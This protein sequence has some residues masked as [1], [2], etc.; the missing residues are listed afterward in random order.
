MLSAKSFK[1][2]QKIKEDELINQWGKAKTD[3]FDFEKIAIYS[4][5]K[6]DIFFHRLSA[7]TKADIDFDD[8]FY[9]V[10]R[11]TSRVGQQFLY[12]V[13]S[14][15]TNDETALLKLN[16][17]A[18]FFRDNEAVRIEVQLHLLKLNSDDAYFLPNLLKDHSFVKPI[19]Y[20]FVFPS[21][22]LIPLLVLL[23]PL[24]HTLLLW[25]MVPLAVNVFLHYRNK[26]FTKRFYKLFQQLNIL[27]NICKK[28]NK[29]QLPFD[30]DLVES[31][32]IKLKSIQRKSRL[33][34]FDQ[35]TIKDEL[36]QAS[37]YLYELIKAIFLIEF[38]TFYS[39]LKDIDKKQAE[40][41]YL[42]NYIGQI[43][44][45]L[46][47][48]SLRAAN[49]ST[50]QPDF[51]SASK[52]F[53]CTKVYHP[54]IA[55]CVTND[56]TVATK[57]VLITGSNMSGKTTFLR[58]LALNS[59]LAQT[60]FTCFAES[61][62]TPFV[63]LH[64]SVRIDDNLLD[65]KS[66]YFEEVTV[67]AALI[68]QAAQ[69]WQNIFMLDEV[70]KGTNTVERIASSKAILSYLNKNNNLVFVTSHDVEL[71]T[72]LADEYELYHF[73]E[74]FE[75][76]GLHF[77][78]LLKAGSLK[79]T[80]AIKILGLSDYPAEIINEAQSI[81]ENLSLRHKQMNESFLYV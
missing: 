41:L 11:T 55:D 22:L 9:L 6:K 4:E 28:L 73:A 65:G 71:S 53:S 30:N 67:M 10:D 74:T 18:N 77:D 66:Y 81:S 75:A 69:D 76:D 5:L 36:T 80:N 26:N 45:A 29:K 78:H 35:S 38:F 14:N 32:S 58:T 15:P 42:F 23:S 61:F 17:Q 57:S 43:D 72:L 2:K 19:W 56:I 44:T 21:L 48:A 63:K 70:F 68:K 40:I 12:T 27:I 37:L 1:K 51:L 25:V 34:S 13:I 52:Q 60:I 50:C 47:I 54:L 62:N 20:K 7:Q 39:V 24:H 49:L 8:V 33:L 16:E 46:S 79:T 31:A 64:S 3:P 59:V